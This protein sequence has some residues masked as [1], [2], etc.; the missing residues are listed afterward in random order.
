M[1]DIYWRAKGLNSINLIIG[2]KIKAEF[3]YDFKLCLKDSFIY[4]AI[5]EQIESVN[6][7]SENYIKVYKEVIEKI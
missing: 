1:I 5:V 2:I 7:D 6:S 4:V 3:E